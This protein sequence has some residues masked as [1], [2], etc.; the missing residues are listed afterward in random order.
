LRVIFRYI[1]TNPD[2]KAYIFLHHSRVK[3]NA[4]ICMHNRCIAEISTNI[5]WG[6]I[7]MFNPQNSSIDGNMICAE[8]P[9]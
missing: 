8:G 1:L 3:F 7:F 9:V 4:K 2:R 6:Y 5:T